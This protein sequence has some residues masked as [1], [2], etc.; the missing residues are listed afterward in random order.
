MKIGAGVVA[1]LAGL[2]AACIQPKPLPVLGQ[3][4]EFQL[5]EQD[6]QPFDSKSLAGHLWVADFIYTTCQGPCPMMSSTM[7]RLEMLTAAD[8]PDLRFVS[9]TVDPK[10]DTPP[11][12][13]EY[14]SHFKPTPGRWY[15]LT[16]EQ[17]KLNDLGMNGFHLNSVD[18]SLTHSTRFVL[19]DGKG[20]IRGYYV[21]GE[22]GFQQKLM[23]D[24]RQ[25]HGEQS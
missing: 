18:G 25:L 7:H 11:V 3:L 9:F 2:L 6:G 17:A 13:A 21:T 16:G 4:P 14:A 5:T 20:R 8:I 22:D 15:F 12:L 1:V 23:H 24:I 10:H 19:V